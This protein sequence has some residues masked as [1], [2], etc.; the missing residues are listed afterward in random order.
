[1][2]HYQEYTPVRAWDLLVGVDDGNGVATS[3]DRAF[4]FR[5]PSFRCLIICLRLM[6]AHTLY[7]K[8]R[9]TNV[10]I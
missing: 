9:K 1:M 10:N 5:V 2:C 6:H 8:A 7:T 3:L 4:F